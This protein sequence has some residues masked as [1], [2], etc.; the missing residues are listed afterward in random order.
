MPSSL[1]SRDRDCFGSLL[2]Q[3][4][5]Y[6]LLTAKEEI[7]LSRLVQAGIALSEQRPDGP[8]DA[9]ERRTIRHGVRAS[10]KMMETNMRLVVSITRSFYRAAAAVGMDRD[11]LFSEGCIGLSRAVAK[12]DA[13]KGFKF[14]TY[15][16]W[17]IRQSVF[18]DISNQGFVRVPIHVGQMMR[19]VRK[20]PDSMSFNE[21][22]EAL[23]FTPG[24]AQS[25]LSDEAVQGIGTLDLRT[26][27]NGAA[28]ID[29]IAAADTAPDIDLGELRDAI[30]QL[31]QLEPDV[32]AS[33]ELEIDHG[34][35]RLIADAS[36]LSLPGLRHR[37]Q[38][39]KT[40]LA[41]ARPQLVELLR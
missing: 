38:V 23:G 11:D 16:T 1:Y 33:L 36:G 14:S 24:D 6:P 21:K 41:K 34:T 29:S 2:D 30:E 7:E 19:K 12:F 25:L 15:A 35:P 31:R 27:P 18:R 39:A 5:R 26:D 40:R 22:V 28:V 20:L 3:F 32:I 8:L 9:A 17:W 37:Q 13:T 10:Q 4:S